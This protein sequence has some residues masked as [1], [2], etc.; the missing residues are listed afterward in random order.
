MNRTGGCTVESGILRFL[1]YKMI[2]VFISRNNGNV[3]FIRCGV[4]DAAME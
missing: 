1:L 4:G 2:F 3:F